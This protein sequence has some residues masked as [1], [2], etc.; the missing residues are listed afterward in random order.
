MSLG[1]NDTGFQARYA[2]QANIPK[3]FDLKSKWIQRGVRVQKSN[4]KQL[5]P[6]AT[7]YHV[8]DY[9]EDHNGEPVPYVGIDNY[10]ALYDGG[11]AVAK[12][13]T[14]RNFFEEGN[15]VKGLLM[16]QSKVE[17]LYERTI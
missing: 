1:I 4:K 14:E 6:T 11:A 2:V 3:K 16:Q 17:V 12:L 5:Q 9:M 10:D 15:V 8:D 7:V 13:A